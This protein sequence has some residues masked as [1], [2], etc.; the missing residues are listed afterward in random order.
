MF[1]ISRTSLLLTLYKHHPRQLPPLLL[2]ND[3]HTLHLGKRLLYQTTFSTQDRLVY[4]V[5]IYDSHKAQ[6][7]AVLSPSPF[8]STVRDTEYC[9]LKLDVP[10]PFQS[11][12]QSA[13]DNIWTERGE[14]ISLIDGQGLQP[15]PPSKPADPRV[16]RIQKKRVRV[17]S[18]GKQKAMQA[19]RSSTA[20]QTVESSATSVNDSVQDTDSVDSGFRTNTVTSDHSIHNVV[21]DTKIIS[22]SYP[23]TIQPDNTGVQVKSLDLAAEDDN[24]LSKWNGLAHDEQLALDVLKYK[25][26]MNKTVNTLLTN[27]DES[28]DYVTSLNG[29]LDTSGTSEEHMD[30]TRE[31]EGLDVSAVSSIQHSELDSSLDEVL[32]SYR[33]LPKSAERRQANVTVSYKSQFEQ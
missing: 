6:V 8:P 16:M 29:R 33:S 3:P 30:S 21:E 12:R 2:M 24:E 9:S 10:F 28:T 17:I 5:H 26:K 32:Y 25:V 13:V 22:D 15:R 31:S 11:S 14:E 27:P 23:P 18:G 1:N 19:T 20:P 7:N 4:T